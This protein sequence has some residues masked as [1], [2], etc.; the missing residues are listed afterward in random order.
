ML[1]RHYEEE[2]GRL[3]VL[4]GEFARDNPALAPMLLGSSADPD[5][6]RL[7]EG[8]AFLTALLRRKLD[9]AFPEFIQDLT[10]LLLPHYLL[11]MPCSALI[12]LRPRV[13][14]GH[15]LTIP[16]GTE[17]LS[18]PVDGTICRFR[19]CHDLE[20][21]PL[22]ILECSLQGAPGKASA[23]RLRLH[24]GGSREA[25]RLSGLRLFLGGIHEL[26]VGCAG[27]IALGAACETDLAGHID[28][29]YDYGLHWTAGPAYSFSATQWRQQTEDA[30]VTGEQTVQIAGGLDIEA[31]TAMAALRKKVEQT[32][33]ANVA[34]QAVIATALATRTA[35]LGKPGEG[36]SED[37]GV[38]LMQAALAG[39]SVLLASLA[40]RKAIEE[41]RALGTPIAWS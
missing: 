37:L 34:A 1:N 23:I 21:P 26:V 20:V 22:R 36:S 13:D 11:S 24:H 25:A 19:T 38:G 6:E 4:A 16:R 33:L 17:L 27:E 32:V 7:L 2:L 39:G 3:K 18:V 41:M 40:V 31:A 30:S 5:V 35:L 12:A 14:D 15:A 8:V 9:D 28:C 29:G 10:G